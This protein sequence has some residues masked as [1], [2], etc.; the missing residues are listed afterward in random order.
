MNMFDE[1]RSLKTMIKMLGLTQDEMAKRLGVSQSYIA[2]KLR[3]LSLSSECERVILEGALSERHARAVLKLRSEDARL[4]ALSKIL[5]MKLSVAESEAI[6]DV[7]YDGDGDHRI[8][9]AEK[10]SAIDTFRDNLRHQISTLV[11]LGV[12]A[13]ESMSIYG[14]KTYITV[15]IEED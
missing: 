13:T 9:S 15:C 11:S 12:S 14:K 4:A 1:A 8:Q 7:L 5:K 6:V 3:L 10:L 2:N